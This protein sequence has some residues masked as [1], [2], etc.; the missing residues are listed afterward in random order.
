MVGLQTTTG[1]HGI[2]AIGYRRRKNKLQFT[3]FITG[4]NRFS[5]IVSFNPNTMTADLPRNGA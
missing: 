2:T 5:K 4:R 1:D 3:N